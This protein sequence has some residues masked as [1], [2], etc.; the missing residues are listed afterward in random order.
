MTY[1]VFH[2]LFVVPP[3]LGLLAYHR[4]RRQ[5][6]A[7]RRLGGALAAMAVI[8]LIYTT[9]WDN[10]L[11]ARGVWSYP[12]GRVWFAL[13]YV[14]IEE[15]LFFV[16]QTLLTGLWLAA[17]WPAAPPS[18][19]ARGPRAG[20]VRT[21][22]A[23]AFGAV[24]ALGA[25]LLAFPKGLYLGL[26]LVWAGPVL[27][28][29]WG[30]GGDLL[31]RRWRL[32][33]VAALPVTIYLSL[34]D[35]F[36]LARGIWA[37]SPAATTGIHLGGLP[38]EEGAFFLATNL[39]ITLGLTLVL[40]ERSPGRLRALLA[41]RSELRPFLQRLGAV[42][43][44]RRRRPGGAR[45]EDVRSRDGEARP[46]GSGSGRPRRWWRVALVAWALAMVPVPL[47]GEAAFVPLAYLSTALLA[48]GVFGLALQR[49]GWRAVP[50]AAAALA[51]G[52]AVEL[53]G[54]RTGLP[55]GP[56]GYLDA[57]PALLGVPLLV[58]LG[59]FAFTVLAL[60]LVPGRRRWWGAAAALV[61]WDAGL[62]PLMVRQGLWRFDPAGA[63]FGVPLQNFAGW[64]VAGAALAALLVRIAPGLGEGGPSAARTVYLAQ[65]AF[66][67]AGLA[68]FGL[69]VAGLVAAAA[70][71]SVAAGTLGARRLRSV[72]IG[73]LTVAIG[74]TVPG[75]VAR[76]LRRGLVGVWA[77]DEGALP[78]AGG[79][80]LAAN[81]HSWWDG[82]LL[83]LLARR[84]RRPFTVLMSEAQLARFPFFRRQGAIGAHELRSAL[85]RL[86]AGHLVTVFP[87][88]ALRP[89]GP[90]APLAPG[91]A[92]LAARSGR[93][94]VPVAVRVAVRGQ[95]RPEA[96]LR[97]GAALAPD[98]PDLE[99]SLADA[100]EALVGSLDAELA[101]AD[102]E[103]PPAGYRRWLSGR[104]STDRRL[105]W[106]V[107]LWGR[108]AG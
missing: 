59:W 77:R 8:A 33:L 40:D 98:T 78:G 14:P 79:V 22:G 10:L 26:V 107:R 70:M 56:Y 66:I 93:P 39:M 51:F 54:S 31:V 20:A 52:W 30:F 29:Q 45:V 9:P 44:G 83:Y 105:A 103:A 36:A 5:A 90:P 91:A 16:L 17:L 85:R 97:F 84:T 106:G 55:F 2:L 80:V 108:E 101:V 71:V 60:Q 32:L 86:E 92:Y 50:A 76:S 28:L 24:A 21:T 63:Y 4:F 61:A 35:R 42:G 27:A 69:P 58:P 6:A 99:R 68:L 25:L 23:L 75:L 81:H 12:P 64:A 49:A 104:A 15:Y 53:L 41:R 3:L 34:A 89:S 46:G 100:L 47:L 82:Y 62:D 94:L 102:P 67:G 43:P 13:G 95:Q 74:W 96:F 73:A 57:G 88:A 38:L 1:F 87:E 65:A 18:A 11:V 37:I 19:G 48:A 7:P 72:W